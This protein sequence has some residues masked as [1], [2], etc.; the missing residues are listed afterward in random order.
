MI[1]TP[2][3][4]R[5]KE[6]ARFILDMHQMKPRKTTDEIAPIPPAL[7]KKYIGYANRNVIPQLSPEAAEAIEDFYVGLRKRAEGGAAP[8]PITARQLESLVRLAE[9]RARMALRTNVT[10]EDGQEAVKLMRASLQM[11]A[12][13]VETGEYDIDRV[14]SEQ[15]ASQRSARTMIIN[16]LREMETDGSDSEVELF[17]RLEAK[18]LPR[19]RAETIIEQLLREGTVYRPKGEGSGT[20]RISTTS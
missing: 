12:F 13:D 20:I 5:D 14:I 4:E 16:T 8:V 9:A 15:S 11:V 1:D 7:L 19:E 10:K 6:L 2:D 18:G 3:E 17:Q